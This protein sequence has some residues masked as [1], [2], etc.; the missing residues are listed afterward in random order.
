MLRVRRPSPA[1]VISLIALF[2]SLGG[3]AYAA[4]SFNGKNIKSRS[5]T[6]KKIK[7]STITGAEVGRNKLTGKN[8]AESKLGKVPKA[9]RA[10]SAASA[11]HA[12]TATTASNAA[13]ATTATTASNATHAASTDHATSADTAT[14]ADTATNATKALD[15]TTVGGARITPIYFRG[16]G[17]S[18]VLDV[19]GLTL[20]ADCNIS[21]GTDLNLVARTT[22]DNAS[23][24]YQEFSFGGGHVVTE[25]PSFDTGESP[26]LLG[27]S[28]TGVQGTLTYDAQ[29]PDGAPTGANVVTVTLRADEVPTATACEVSGT[30]ISTRKPL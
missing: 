3:G 10:D 13:H 28:D 27:S 29:T 6:G 1:L 14:H 21:G 30:A 11:D 26:D 5:I 12:A 20:E 16:S 25:D 24:R 15:A 8:I 18:T 23:I 22:N 7:K 4:V 19:G 17:T 9:K 2:A